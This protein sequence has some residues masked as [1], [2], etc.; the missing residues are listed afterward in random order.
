MKRIAFPLLALSAGATLVLASHPV[1]AHG[2]TGAGVLGGFSHPLLGL[3]HLLMLISVGASASL[4]G[5]QLLVWALGGA[6]I[7][8]AIGSGSTGL[9]SVEALAALAIVA[10]S[11][12]ILLASHNSSANPSATGCLRNRRWSLAFG[13]VVSGAVAIH[14]WLHGLEAPQDSTSLLWWSGALMSS[15]L[16]AT[17]SCM[18]LRRLPQRWTH[19][20]ATALLLLGAGLSLAGMGG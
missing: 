5:P 17:A 3:D 1:M 8:A 15:A 19:L 16:V 11:L 6:L 13:A 20:T 7:G 12:L 2:T 10:V 9:A 4:V 18:T 14:A